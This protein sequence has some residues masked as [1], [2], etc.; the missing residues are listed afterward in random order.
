ML[1]VLVFVI[2]VVS[3]AISAVCYRMWHVLN[4]SPEKAMV[5]FQLNPEVTVSEFRILLYAHIFM[6]GLMVF[7]TAAAVLERALWSQ[8]GLGLVAGYGLTIT[9]VYT[10]WWRRF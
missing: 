10:T 7:Y 5:S 4:D 1:V 6:T 9:Y 2:A 3:A 8:I